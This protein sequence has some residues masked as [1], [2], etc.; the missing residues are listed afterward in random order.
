[1]RS[2]C[3]KHHL[4]TN[5]TKDS[6][7]NAFYALFDFCQ[8]TA[9]FLEQVL[10]IAVQQIRKDRHSSSFLQISFSLILKFLAFRKHRQTNYKIEEC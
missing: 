10:K 5:K 7:F 6:C 1:M 4:K 8:Q 9:D 2:I 3:K